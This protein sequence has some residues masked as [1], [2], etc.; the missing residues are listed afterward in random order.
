M[1]GFN[2]KFAGKADNKTVSIIAKEL[3]STKI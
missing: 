2:S 3:L 1:G